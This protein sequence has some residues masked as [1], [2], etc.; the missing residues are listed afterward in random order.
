MKDMTSPSIFTCQ[1]SK[2]GIHYSSIQGHLLYSHTSPSPVKLNRVKM[3]RNSLGLNLKVV[4]NTLFFLKTSSDLQFLMC[5][6]A[7]IEK[8]L[9]FKGEEMSIG[10]LEGG[11]WRGGDRFGGE[12][13]DL[14][15]RR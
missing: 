2:K 6:I 10:D 15:G 13:I 14:E 3:N 1:I 7:K 4:R 5:F 9:R 12:E 8:A 11:I